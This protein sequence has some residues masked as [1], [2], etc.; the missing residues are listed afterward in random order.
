MDQSLIFARH[1]AH[2]VWLFLHEPRSTYEQQT[3]LD[4]L[5]GASREGDV[6]IAFQED[7]LRA[8]GEVVSA[9]LT[10]VSDLIKQMALHGLAMISAEAGALPSDIFGVA[11]ILAAMPVIGDGGD[12]AEAKRL[13]I[14]VRTI[15]FAARPR[16]RSDSGPSLT[17][18]STREIAAVGG[19]LPDMELGDVL[20]DPIAEAKA[21]AKATPR[22]TQIVTATSTP[23]RGVGT[24][25]FAQ[26]AAAR[27]PQ[28]STEHLLARLGVLSD[29]AV[30]A[31]VVGD[32]S[33]H[34][35]DAAH[36][37]K[38]AVVS[39]IMSRIA[40]REAE[41]EDVDAKRACALAFS[42]LAR[43]MVLRVVASQLPRHIDEREEFIAVLTRAGDLGAEAIIEQLS[44]AGHQRERRVFFDALLQLK[45]SVPF[46]L[47]MLKDSRWFV[48]RNAA[49]LLGEMQEREGEVPLTSLLRHEDERVRRT[50][51]SA[52]MRLGTPRAL[53]AIEEGIKDLD[54]QMRIEAAA[55]IV[56][57]KDPQAT[58][59][60]LKALDVEKD[61]D[62]QHAFLGSLGK[63]ASNDAV[64][65]LIKCAGPERSLFKKKATET[66]VAATHALGE[67]GTPEALEALRSL[68]SDKDAEVRSAA[69][70]ALGRATRRATTSVR[71]VMTPADGAPKP[72]LP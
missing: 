38:A 3:V 69:N 62:V 20:D 1:F 8:N 51:R 13:E 18:P 63:I 17:P 35:E 25:L 9:D 14:G 58:M 60:L 66:R 19:S 40:L 22:N 70:I 46:L 68:Q 61:D 12:A 64:H 52:L 10:G 71:P 27:T 33:V 57:R 32:L 36:E 28:D 11:G 59:T 56:T 42:R 30:I 65:R 15:R 55:A 34:A 31:Q 7:G 41:L 45:A 26:F 50:A 21:K 53:Q 48:V 54:A 67:A 5:V 2:L 49:E 39:R 44:T 43:L 16:P 24:G 6:T 47:H 4:A 23:S 29:A 72:S 37:G